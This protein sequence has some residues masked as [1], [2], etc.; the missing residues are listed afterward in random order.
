M[1]TEEKLT[2]ASFGKLFLAFSMVLLLALFVI[3]M[4]TSA[5]LK[6][7]NE[8]KLEDN[9]STKLDEVVSKCFLHNYI[10]NS[11]HRILIELQKN[12]PESKNLPDKIKDCEFYD[13]ISLKAFFYKNNELKQSVNAN[14][15]DLDLF[16]DLFVHISHNRLDEAFVDS[17]RKT[18]NKLVSLFGSGTRLEL[19]QLRK[20]FYTKYSSPDQRQHFYFNTFEDGNGMG[21][22]GGD[23]DTDF[24]LFIQQGKGPEV[25]AGLPGAL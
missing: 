19:L 15:D 17:H 8:K 24:Y 25:P 13:N 22:F 7:S 11:W 10:R 12:G 9:L 4:Q 21:K 5:K 6:E 23:A 1:A 14:T 3:S 18:L 20:S 2:S 16:K